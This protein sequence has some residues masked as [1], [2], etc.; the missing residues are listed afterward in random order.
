MGPPLVQ[1]PCNKYPKHEC[2]DREENDNTPDN[3]VG[4]DKEES[5]G[6]GQDRNAMVQ[7]HKIQPMFRVEVASPGG[8]KWVISKTRT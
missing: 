5:K 3:G 2:K 1:S 8:K 7:W 6:E 4:D